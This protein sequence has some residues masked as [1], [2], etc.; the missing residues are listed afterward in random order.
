MVAMEGLALIQTHR[1]QGRADG[2]SSR[3]EDRTRHEHLGM[4][5]DALGD[6]LGEEWRKGDQ[7]PY[8]HGR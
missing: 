5:E 3:S 1:S 7:N 6:A 2:A 8:H 4:L